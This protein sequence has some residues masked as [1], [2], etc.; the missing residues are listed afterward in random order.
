MLR[1]RAVWGPYVPYAGNPILTQRELPDDRPL[2]ITNAGHA[3]LVE[4]PDGSWWAV[5]LASRNYQKR[6]YNTGRE[7]Y[8]LPVRWQDGWPQILPT[9]QAIPYVAKAPSWM[10]GEASQAPST[11][12]FVARDN[13]DGPALDRQWL[14][15]RAQAC[16]G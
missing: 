8:L 2:P 1:S 10:Q 6:H 7:T 12:N 16:Q 3:G 14:R 15:V 13:F 5:F 4:G 11:G 9:D